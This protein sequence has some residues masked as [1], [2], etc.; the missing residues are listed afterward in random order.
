MDAKTYILGLAAAVVLLAGVTQTKA[1]LL[2]YDGFESGSGLGQ[3]PV[4]VGLTSTNGGSGWTGFWTSGGTTLN[5]QA[6]GLT[7]SGLAT[8]AGQAT[9]RGG[10]GFNVNTR[11]FATVSTG[12]LWVSWLYSPGA[13][14][15][16]YSGLGIT[17]SVAGESVYVGTNGDGNLR[18]DTTA[19]GGTNLSTYGALTAGTRFIVA[20]I[21][22]T[23]S[24]IAVYNNPTLPGGPGSAI[25]SF[26][27]LTLTNATGV[28]F[29]GNGNGITS[30]DE[31]R[32]G[33]TY[34]DVAA[35]PEPSTYVLLLGGLALLGFLRRTP[36]SAV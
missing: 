10:N 13:P 7:Y 19:V 24:T 22:F 3:Y 2:V 25:A 21:N 26:A 8:T 11:T 32:V 6:G 28:V 31:I 15:T 9:V 18:I 1:A 30:F 35:I 17:R 23:N 16:D 29:L 12:D 20:N 33:T 4:N 27:G 34:A 36:K 5:S 14:A